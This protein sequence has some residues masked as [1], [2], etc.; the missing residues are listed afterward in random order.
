MYCT[1]YD[2]GR[3]II[4]SGSRSWVGV[5]NGLLIGGKKLLEGRGVP[6]MSEWTHTGLDWIWLDQVILERTVFLHN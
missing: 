4:Q 1:G 5:L 3:L 6:V 2:D